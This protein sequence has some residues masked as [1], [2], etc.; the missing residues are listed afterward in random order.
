VQADA[1]AL[2]LS[3]GMFDAAFAGLW[4]SHVPV[5]RRGEFLA[6][7]HPRLES[8]ARVVLIDNTETQCERLPITGRDADGNTYQQRLLP[9]GTTHR[10]LKNFP[11]RDEL[12]TLIDGVGTD[13]QYWRGE[14]FWALSYDLTG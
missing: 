2:P 10:V 9:D 12:R 1:F 5:Q 13:I 14:H 3:L 7:L 8:G 11:S 4:F 6:G